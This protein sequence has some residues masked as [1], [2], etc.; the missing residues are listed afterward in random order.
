MSETSRLLTS[1]CIGVCEIDS[2]TG[3]CLGCG[4]AA[5]EI[6]DW[7][8]LAPAT[9]TAVWARL[10]ERLEHLE[11]PMR[12]LPWSPGALLERLAVLT[13][14]PGAVWSIGVVGASA[15]LLGTADDELAVAVADAE[16]FARHA[17]GA[18][19]LQAVAGLRAFVQRGP[20]GAE[21]ALA[22]HRSRL[23]ET[24]PEVVT[25]LGPDRDALVAGEAG[26]ALFDLGLGCAAGIRF[27][28][29]SRE[30][31]L[32]EALTA[33]TGRPLWAGDL[34]ARLVPA[35][36][37]RV[38]MSPVGRLEVTAPIAPPGGTTPPGPHTH[39]FVEQLRNGSARQP[40]G[41]VP[42]DYVAVARLFAP[43]VALAAVELDLE[44]SPPEA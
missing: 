8:E 17:R 18:L 19:R 36:P 24:P 30:P 26:A 9:R 10:P 34:A 16:L 33:A 13:S 38:L 29:R 4:R 2:T 27:A 22:L 20:H 35:S 42:G 32:V 39:L 7:R 25:A 14:L 31:A 1:P 12:A 5:E 40:G 21:I 41:S 28:V 3:W 11:R 43:E 15:E 23:R 44:P 6:D 37:T